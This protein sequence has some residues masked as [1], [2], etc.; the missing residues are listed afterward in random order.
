VGHLQ[1]QPELWPDPAARAWW[2]AAHQELVQLGVGGWWLDGGEGP[3]AAATLAGGDGTRL[4]NLYDRLR[5]PAFAEGEA[6]DRPDQRVFLLCRSGAAGMQRFGATCWSGDINNDFVTLEAQIPLGLNTGLSGVP[7]W[8]T[9]VAGFFHPIAESGELYARWFQLGAFTPIFRS[10]GT[11]TLTWQAHT[12][13]LPLMRALVLNYPDDPRVWALGHQFLWGDDLLVAPV[14]REGATAWPVYVP[15]GS[16]YDFWTGARYEG[17]AG[18]TLDAPLDRLPL[19]VRAGAI[20]PLGP[21][22]QH[23]VPFL[24]IRGH[25]RSL[26]SR[27]DGHCQSRHP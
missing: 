22:L 9:D 11:Y 20:V 13:G 21:I 16:W 1:F 12:L 18:V 25:E 6:A 19:L 23:R 24:V 27:D 4:H 15:T 7:Y 5:H 2:W 3:P 10:H 8:G 26:P 17:P 14:T